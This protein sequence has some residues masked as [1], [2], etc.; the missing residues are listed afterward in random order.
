M[1]AG[2]A[3]DAHAHEQDAD[4]IGCLAHGGALRCPSGSEAQVR[5]LAML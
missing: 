5:A 4:P 1:I 3:P 2:Q